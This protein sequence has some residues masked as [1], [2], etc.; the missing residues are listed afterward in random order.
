VNRTTCEGVGSREPTPPMTY[1]D[2]HTDFASNEEHGKALTT[3]TARAALSGCTLHEIAYSAFLVAR[4]NY[5]RALPCLGGVGDTLR[6]IG[7]SHV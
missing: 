2:E 7:G 1:N 5:S 3:M 4:R 6:Q